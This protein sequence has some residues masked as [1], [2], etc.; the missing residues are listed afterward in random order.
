VY[1]RFVL[2][3]LRSYSEV[4]GVEGILSELDTWCEVAYQ[5]ANR[6]TTQGV[7]EEAGELGVTVG[8]PGLL[9]HNDQRKRIGTRKRASLTAP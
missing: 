6:V 7:L 2:D 4:K 5:K 9:G 3:I 1:N 8:N